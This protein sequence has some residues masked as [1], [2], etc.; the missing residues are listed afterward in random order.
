[1]PIMDSQLLLCEE[2]SV[3]AAAGASTVSTNVIYLPA[4]VDHKGTSIDDRPNQSGRLYFNVVVE[5]TAL[6]AAVDGS[7]VTFA[8]YNDTD[9]TPTTGGTV[10]CS[11]AVTCNT[12][13]E[14]PDGT[15]I[16]SIPL[17]ATTLEAYYGM[18]VSVATQELSAG[19]VTAWI[20]GPVHSNM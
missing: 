13:T 10:I 2:L 16:C 4:P 11:K 8:L 7:V 5:G 3:A 9:S 15:L 19:T 18:L 12:P 17:P 6:L 1:M 14:H 20:G